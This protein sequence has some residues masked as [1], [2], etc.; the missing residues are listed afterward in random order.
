MPIIDV[1]T[2][3]DEK[4][5]DPPPGRIY[6]ASQIPLEEIT[7]RV[8]NAIPQLKARQSFAEEL[9]IAGA[10]PKDIARTIADVLVEGRAGER[11]KAS[12]I[13]MRAMGLFDNPGNQETHIV[14]Q[15]QGDNVNLAAVL[16]PHQ[17]RNSE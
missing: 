6:Q 1:E 4:P 9:L 13:A 17:E 15:I 8:T 2:V 10:G 3:F 14:F 11:L 5:A 12:E 16:Q 7:N